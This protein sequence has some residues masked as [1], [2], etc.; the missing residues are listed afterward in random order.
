MEVDICNTV[1]I[2]CGGWVGLMVQLSIANFLN[3]PTW[4]S[5]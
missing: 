4:F 1:G 5:A 3:Y 2:V